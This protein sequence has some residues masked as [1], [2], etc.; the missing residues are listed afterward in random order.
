MD[1]AATVPAVS[2][3]GPRAAWNHVA[4][5]L[6]RGVSANLIARWNGASWQPVGTGMNWSVQ[7]LCVYNGELYAGG[8]F[9]TAGG[10][11]P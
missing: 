6:S 2:N 7:A 11:S 8:A 9:T 3:P 5:R 1:K 4:D 10:K